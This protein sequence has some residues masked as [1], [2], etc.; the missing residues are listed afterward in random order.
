MVGCLL[1]IFCAFIAMH[2]TKAY[3]QRKH[4]FLQY[5]Q[6]QTHQVVSNI[7]SSSPSSYAL[8]GFLL[9]FLLPQY[10]HKL[11]RELVTRY[12]AVALPITLD[13]VD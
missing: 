13:K 7:W 12:S 5:T 2:A 1:Y 6:L 3:L 10:T 9:L 11:L 4:V 8:C